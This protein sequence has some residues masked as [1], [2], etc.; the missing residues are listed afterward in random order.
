MNEYQPTNLQ[1]AELPY[2]IGCFGLNS[3]VEL[4]GGGI[5]R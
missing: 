4:V 3:Q 5:V 2:D 1:A